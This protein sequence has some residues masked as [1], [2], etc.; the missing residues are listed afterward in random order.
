MN[1]TNTDARELLLA[2]KDSVKSVQIVHVSVDCTVDRLH[3]LL[4]SGI[5][6]PFDYDSCEIDDNK[7]DVWGWVLASGTNGKF[8]LDEFRLIVQC[9]PEPTDDSLN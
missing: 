1:E 6:F 3:T 5:D 4:T 9:K 2:I 8:L 7:V